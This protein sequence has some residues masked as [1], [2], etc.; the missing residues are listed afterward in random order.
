MVRARIPHGSDQTLTDAHGATIGSES[1]ATR[2]ILRDM[3]GTGG[4]GTV[5]RSDDRFAGGEVAVKLLHDL[6]STA[7]LRFER[8]ATLLASLSHPAIVRYIDH[9]TTTAGT[10]Y[11]VME[12]LEGETLKARLRRGPLAPFDVALLAKNVLEALSAAHE[13]GIVHRDVKPGNLFVCGEDPLRVKV[14]DFGIAASEGAQQVTGEHSALGTPAYMAPE[15][16]RSGRDVDGRADLFALGCVVYECLTGAPAFV[17]ASPLAVLAKICLDDTLDVAGDLS[18][19]PAPLVALVASMLARDRL[20]RP[21][22]AADL[23]A[24][25]D[26][27]LPLLRGLRAAPVRPGA[28]GPPLSDAVEQRIASIVALRW[29]LDGSE[30]KPERL[31]EIENEITS[32][33]GGRLESFVAGTAVVRL[34]S[35]SVPTD[36]AL[37]AARC[38]LRIRELAPHVTVAIATGRGVVTGRSL[39]GDVIDEAVRRLELARPGSTSVDDTTTALLGGQVD[40]RDGEIFPATRANAWGRPRTVLGKDVP[41]I[42]RD[43]ELS[44]LEALYDECRAEPVARAVLITAPAGG[45][46]SRIRHEL[47]GR[48]R[49]RGERPLVLLGEGDR[50]RAGSPLAVLGSAIR[51]ASGVQPTDIP[52]VAHGRIAALVQSVGKDRAE[53]AAFLGEIAGVHFPDEGLVRL[54]AARQDSRLMTDGMMTAWCRWLAAEAETRPVILILED[55]HWADGPTVHFVDAALRSL[56]ESPLLVVALARPEIADRFVG[57]WS[58]RALMHF[59][60]PPLTKK[61]CA[62]IVGSLLDTAD[63]TQVALIVK[64]AEG[65]PFVLEEVVRAAAEGL[66][67]SRGSATPTVLAMAQARFDAIGGDAK[68]VLRA[69]AVFGE[70]FAAEGVHALIGGDE[71]ALTEWLDILS[72]REVV[73]PRARTTPTGIGAALPYEWSFRHALLRDAAYELLTDEDRIRAH[74][75]AALW[76]EGRGHVE[77]AVLAEHFERGGNT[78]KAAY[79]TCGTAVQLLEAN[80]FAEAVE[81]VGHGVRLQP[82]SPTLARLR[83]VEAQ[84]HFWRTEYVQAE[85]AAR[86]ALLTNDDVQR[87]HAS[88]ELINALGQQARFED[89]EAALLDLPRPGP[90]RAMRS[91]YAACLVNA[92]GYL[93]P[94]GRHELASKLLREAEGFDD[95]MDEIV[96]ARLTK[97]RAFFAVIKGDQAGALMNLHRALRAFENAGDVRAATEVAVNIG[98]VLTDIG[99]LGE[100]E[101]RLREMLAVTEKHGIEYMR[102]GVAL[103][104]GLVYTY[105]GR[106]D[107]ARDAILGVRGAIEK[108]GDLRYTGA[109]EMWLSILA[110]FAQD[111]VASELHARAALTSWADV[112][113]AYPTALAALARAVSAQGRFTEAVEISHDA[114]ARLQALGGVEDMEALIP[115]AHAECL[116]AAGRM[117]EAREVLSKA[118]RRLEERADAI[119]NPEWR[120]SFLRRLPFHA[121][122]LELCAAHC[123]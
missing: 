110:N 119:D 105:L 121:R 21:A 50:V 62:R 108:Q 49:E 94:G 51:E 4:M 106:L 117:D 24:Q 1:I 37:R 53:V 17:G 98:V 74:E 86:R 8:E 103:N 46:K 78:E 6:G 120:E 92:I 7:V 112:P 95:A 115:L 18:T 68:R 80:Q 97:Q 85:E 3:V 12:W 109:A 40:V 39:I 100:A 114:Y 44:S 113:P 35:E 20:R 71:R 90:D 52:A 23:A 60:L 31:A 22:T 2:F 65:N 116:L 101:Q 83:L 123:D 73:F 32:A 30:M 14:L 70:T 77:P 69:G 96:R 25:F 84:A 43:R 13:R 122:T 15:Q 5:Y 99:Q 107:E 33:F 54:G 9:G 89:L 10:R 45:G 38:A 56:A 102:V 63:A 27:I 111:Y 55:L 58:E 82:D 72:A 67:I 48:L 42:G 87:L 79:W 75:A 93:V 16:A 61:A 66:D 19:F 81:R 41:C 47:L 28:A 11:I 34:P 26:A 29:S 57:L 64:R 118:R 76:L 59:A 88:R 91:A 104:L 36:H